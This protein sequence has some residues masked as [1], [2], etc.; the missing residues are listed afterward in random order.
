MFS[1]KDNKALQQKYQ[2]LTQQIEQL[3]VEGQAGSGLVKITLNGRMEVAGLSIS[4]ECVDKDEVSV[5]EDLILAAFKDAQGKLQ[6][7]M[8]QMMPMMGGGLGF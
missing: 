8:S 3:V 5:L 1:K 4:P 6:A 7:K 2:E